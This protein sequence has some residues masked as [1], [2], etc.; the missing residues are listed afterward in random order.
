MYTYSFIQWL[1]FFYIYCFFG[2]CFESAYVSAK[3]RQLVNRGF[4]NGP[5]LPIY[6]S[7]AITVLFAA[8]PFQKYPVAVYFV[9]LFAATLLELVTGIVMESLFKVRYWDYSYQKFQY[10]GYICLSS[11]IAWGFFSVAM[12]YGFHKP[13]ERFVLGL[14]Q[15]IVT[16]GT[17]VLTVIIAADFATSFKTALELRDMLI[18]LEKAKNELRLM[19]K[20]MEVIEAVLADEAKQHKE[21]FVEKKEQIAEKKEQ[22]I[23]EGKEQL[24]KELEELRKKEF[25]GV[26]KVK[27]KL[28]V[29]RDKIQMLRRNPSAHSIQDYSQSFE[30]LKEGFGEM[31]EYFKSKEESIKEKT[32]DKMAERILEISK[33]HK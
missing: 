4:L 16:F 9:G 32:I 2:W 1:L 11:S 29:G 3:K 15:N 8:L 17:F 22:F 23:T 13:V 33:K 24:L 25:A 7:G 14:P 21:Q 6:G 26:E 31:K 20:R 5:F 10:K 12:V 18:A 28:S 30:L 19:R 27:Q